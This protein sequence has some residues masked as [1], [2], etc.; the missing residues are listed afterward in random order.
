MSLLKEL[1]ELIASGIITADQADEIERHF[2]KKAEHSPNRQIIVFSI[3]GAILVGLGIILILAHNW[4]DLPRP[5]KVSL[6]FIPLFVA[7]FLCYRGLQLDQVPRWKESAATFLFFMVG[8]SIA[9]ISQIYQLGGSLSTFMLTWLLLTLPMIYLLRSN[10]VSLLY[11][12]GIT[13]STFVS[14]Y[15]PHNDL[16]TYW[17][18][19]ALALP[20]CYML[21]RKT[22][23]S[24]WVRLHTWVLAVSI[25]IGFGTFAH[26]DESL[27][28]VGYMSLFG[29]YYWVGKS[30]AFKDHSIRSNAFTFFGTFGTIILLF[31]TSFE[32]YW[33][34][35][36]PQVLNGVFFLQPE[37]IG[38]MAASLLACLLLLQVFRKNKPGQLDLLGLAFLIFGALFI[39]SKQYP[40]GQ[41][42]INMLLVGIG[43]QITTKGSKME[44]LGTLNLGL[45]LLCT[46]ISC[47]FFDTDL[48][49]FVKGIVFVA[50]GVALFVVNYKMIQKRKAND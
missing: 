12:I 8:A 3:L 30:S 48:P 7:Q 21:Y 25:M 13:Y 28:L 49:F 23:D 32:W 14:E 31:F 4:Q 37:F 18:L 15:F 5:I 20:Y 9:L 38:V 45:L 42:G 24:H 10:M 16:V 19:L 2:Q 29:L 6:A 27:L 40:I 35:R 33:T 36:T 43:L 50:M 17:L 22:P 26:K 46:W 34:S 41:L 1:P 39:V 47:R 11:L 44:Q